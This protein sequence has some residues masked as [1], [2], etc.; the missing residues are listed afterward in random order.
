MFAFSEDSRWFV[1][2]YVSQGPSHDLV[3]WEWSDEAGRPFEPTIIPT[4]GC[5]AMTTLAVSGWRGTPASGRLL[6]DGK[7]PADA[8]AFSPQS[9]TTLAV[10]AFR[11]DSLRLHLL[12][13]SCGSLLSVPQREPTGKTV[14][15]LHAVIL[16]CFSLTRK[17]KNSPLPFL[18]PSFCSHAPDYGNFEN[19]RPGFFLK[20]KKSSKVS[21]GNSQG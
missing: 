9:P 13:V 4:Q 5:S 16:I 10:G 3:V 20:K 17:Q 15:P 14:W 21:L 19:S 6:G 2:Q 12:D 18:S 8:L 11:G 1:H 7:A